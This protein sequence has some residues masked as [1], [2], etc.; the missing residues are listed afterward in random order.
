MIVV[1]VG[2]HAVGKSSTCRALARRLGLPFDPEIGAELAQDPTWRAQDG[3]AE[4]PQERFDR[5]VL[6]REIARDRQRL[7]PAV[8]ETWH[9]GNLAYAAQRNPRV[10]ADGLAALRRHPLPP[11][12][13]VPLMAPREVLAARAWEAGDVAF[14][15]RVGR[16]APAWA[17]R[18][19]LHV[20]PT[21]WTH[22]DPPEALAE[23]VAQL[24]EPSWTACT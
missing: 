11:A 6:A 18:L 8:V 4:D 2:P 23:R 16:E 22:R 12:V 7:G 24:L 5:E 9:P 14:F 15:E 3:L 21:L 13:I 19:G 10:A 17:R 1:V 20:L